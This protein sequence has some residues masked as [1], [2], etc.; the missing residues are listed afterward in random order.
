MHFNDENCLHSLRSN[1][2]ILGPLTARGM[3]LH[4]SV[5][6]LG[7]YGW[8]LNHFMQKLLESNVSSCF[9]FRNFSLLQAVIAISEGY[10][11]VIADLRY[12][13]GTLKALDATVFVVEVARGSSNPNIKQIASREDYAYHVNHFTD[14]MTLS[15]NLSNQICSLEGAPI[16][17]LQ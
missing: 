2:K 13:T 5:A 6:Y 14:L 4:L 1:R 3:P 12:L 9:K 11:D 10:G 15:S 16:H 7:F 8:Q 17:A